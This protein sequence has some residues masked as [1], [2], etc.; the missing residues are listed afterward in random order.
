MLLATRQQQTIHRFER[1]ALRFVEGRKTNVFSQ[2]NNKSLRE[3]I[4]HGRYSGLRGEALEKY[5]DALD[6]PLGTFLLEIKLRGD[7]FYKKFLNAYGDAIYSTFC[8]ADDSFL[9]K[10]GVYAYVVDGNVAYI[11]RCRDS[12]S[13][14]INQGYGKIHPKNCYVDGQATNC[15]LNALITSAGVGTELWLC[16]IDSVDDI[17][18]VEVELVRAH[19]PPWNIHRFL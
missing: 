16:P 13:K 12:M 7:L 1:V 9:K 8:I 6:Q 18:V 19:S 2:K 17:S 3:T 15:H 11:G 4:E 5:A 10:R 14:R